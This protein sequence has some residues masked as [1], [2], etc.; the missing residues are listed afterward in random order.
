MKSKLHLTDITNERSV[1]N[2]IICF[3][4]SNSN[5]R[6]AKE[7]HQKHTYDSLKTLYSEHSS[8]SFDD[9]VKSFNRGL[10]KANGYYSPSSNS[11]L[12]RLVYLSYLY[13]VELDI[14]NLE[15]VSKEFE[16]EVVT[17]EVIEIENK[18]EELI[19]F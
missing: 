9:Y 7:L 6:L 15:N 17:Q 10:F 16:K 4:T 18:E 8:S 14:L 13:N 12:F 1:L 19:T 3:T 2:Y 11:S 5:Y